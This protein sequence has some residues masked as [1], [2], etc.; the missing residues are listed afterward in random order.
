MTRT[1]VVLALTALHLTAQTYSTNCLKASARLDRDWARPS[2]TESESI[3]KSL[4]SYA[5]R[6]TAEVA[7][8]LLA[9]LHPGHSGVPELRSCAEEIGPASF[10]ELAARNLHPANWGHVEQALLRAVEHD[11][12]SLA[13]SLRLWENGAK[14]QAAAELLSSAP[15]DRWTANVLRAGYNADGDMLFSWVSAKLNP[16]CNW[17]DAAVTVALNEDRRSPGLKSL[18]KRARPSVQSAAFL[19]KPTTDTAPTSGLLAAC[20]RED[21]ARFLALSESKLQAG[22]RR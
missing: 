18:F 16:T 21:R 8:R 4:L 5:Q 9:R 19:D 12:A 3:A 2:M 17:R 7:E 22:T 6:P 1:L 14:L 10:F 13:S 11:R 20:Y 15:S